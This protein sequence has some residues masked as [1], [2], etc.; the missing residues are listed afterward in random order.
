MAFRSEQVFGHDREPPY[1]AAGCVEH[2]VGDCR[3]HA[4]DREFSDAL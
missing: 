1:S 3:G 4:Y 2:G